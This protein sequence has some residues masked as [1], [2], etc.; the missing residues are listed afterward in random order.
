MT[1]PYFH[2]VQYYET[3][4]MGITHHSN[5]I[6]WMEEARANWMEQIGFGYARLEKEGVFSPVVNVDCKFVATTTFDDVVKIEIKVQEY[7]GVRLVVHYDMFKDD[8]LVLTGTSTHCFLDKN[9]RPVR[10]KNTCPTL[11]KL[12]NEQKNN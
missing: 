1:K 11:D 5:Y 8:V 3:D 10:L 4:K 7:S 9:Y 12:L 2:H 6:R